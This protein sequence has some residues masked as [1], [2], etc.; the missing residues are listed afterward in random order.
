MES[1][2][3]KNLIDHKEDTY[4]KYQTKKWYVI[5]DQNNGQYGEGDNNDDTVKIDTEAVKS[6]LCDYADANILV[7][8]DITAVGGNINTRLLLK[9]VIHSLKVKSI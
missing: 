7:T 3:I 8:G 5:N 2:K 9:T 6:F 4:S 1:Q